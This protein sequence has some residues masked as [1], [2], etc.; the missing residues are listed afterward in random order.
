MHEVEKSQ[1]QFNKQAQ[2]PMRKS[3]NQEP[4]KSPGSP[5]STSSTPR[6]FTPRSPKPVAVTYRKKIHDPVSR[7]HQMQKTWNKD[8][9]LTDTSKQHKNLRLQVRKEMLAIS[10]TVV[11]N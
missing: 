9:F 2:N 5:M 7:F 6:P 4:P 8:R 1:A 11:Y 10:G 3:H